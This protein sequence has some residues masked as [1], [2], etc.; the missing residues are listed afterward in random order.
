MACLGFGVIY[1]VVTLATRRRLDANSRVMAENE[2]RRVQAVQEG[3][4]GIR[5]ILI[6]GTQNVFVNRFWK[7]DA[8]LRQAQAANNFIATAPRYLIESSAW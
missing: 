2:T 8:A 3:L 5:D 1:L 6:D 7:T 4:G